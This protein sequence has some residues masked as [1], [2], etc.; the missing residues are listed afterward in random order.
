MINKEYNIKPFK[1]NWKLTSN[2]LSLLVIWVD[3]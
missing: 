3:Q 2:P 1:L